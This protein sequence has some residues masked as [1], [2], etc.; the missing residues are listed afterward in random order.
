MRLTK[1]RQYSKSMSILG[2]LGKSVFGKEFSPIRLIRDNC[3]WKKLPREKDIEPQFCEMCL[4]YSHYVI[5]SVINTQI[6]PT[7]GTDIINYRLFALIYGTQW[8]RDKYL[9]FTGISTD[10]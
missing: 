7:P 6:H 5:K 1:D 8:F 4:L 3:F 2:E 10:I 9:R